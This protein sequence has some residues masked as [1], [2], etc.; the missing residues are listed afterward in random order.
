[1]KGI[2]FCLVSVFWFLV[3]EG[4]HQNTD[5]KQQLKVLYVG[6]NPD[7]EVPPRNFAHGAG[8]AKS[9]YEKDMKG[10]MPAF[11]KLLKQY[12]AEVGTVDARKYCEEMTREYDVIIFDA[13]PEPIVP[14][15][16]RAKPEL[17]HAELLPEST[18]KELSNVVDTKE[19]FSAYY[20]SDEYSKPTLFV[21]D[22]AGILG[23][24]L[25]LKL[26]WFCRCLDAHA[27]DLR[28][29]HPIFHGPLPVDI[30]YERRITPSSAL[31]GVEGVTAPGVMDMWRVQTEGYRE[32]RERYRLGLVAFGDGFEENGDGERIAGGVSDKN[33]DAVSMG[34]H[35]NFFMWGFAADPGYM[36]EVAQ[37]VFVNAICYISKFDG[38]KPITRKF[39]NGYV[40]RNKL[41]RQLSLVERDTFDLYVSSRKVYNDKLMEL[42]HE[43]ENLNAMGKKVSGDLLGQAWPQPQKIKEYDEYLDSYLKSE[44]EKFG[45]SDVQT[46]CRFLKENMDYFYGGT[47]NFSFVLDEDLKQM[48]VAVGDVKVLERAIELL[49]GT[50]EERERGRRLLK[51]YTMEDFSMVEEWKKWLDEVR[52]RLIFT[53]SCGYKFVDQS[54][55][56]A[57]VKRTQEDAQSGVQQENPVKVM[58]LR[59][60]NEIRVQFTIKEGFHIY[61]S[62]GREGAYVLTD[63]KFEYP[64]GIQTAGELVIPEAKVYDADSNVK[65]YEKRAIF[66]QPIQVEPKADKAKIACIV[67]YQ[68]C[69][70]TIC[71]PPVTERVEVINL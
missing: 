9:R 17:R 65:I 16:R 2:I 35:G 14:G 42:K 56:M 68:A 23:A 71:I 50:T 38:K 29:E 32:G 22:K 49:N 48:N 67:T 28:L 36:T 59:K 51:R 26:N 45:Y 62:S 12:F 39:E 4:C 6:F 8:I 31:F 7:K 18:R 21:G 54:R 57:I 15:V 40:T 37:R 46:Y 5:D 63:V 61:A 10:R 58:A 44:A 60:G 1:M 52:E 43:V 55:G 66:I 41:R 69:D 24:S 27:Y 64:Q 33:R 20:F 53:E 30:S 47:G 13:V 25:G 11:E 34:R 70:E 19:L 3:V